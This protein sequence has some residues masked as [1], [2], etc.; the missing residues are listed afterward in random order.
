MNEKIFYAGVRDK[1]LYPIQG[2]D[3][4]VMDGNVYDRC[5]QRGKIRSGVRL[6][7]FH[8][9]LYILALSLRREKRGRLKLSIADMY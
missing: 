5:C 7:C 2:M 1:K 3:V 9:M 6:I 8:T 4:I